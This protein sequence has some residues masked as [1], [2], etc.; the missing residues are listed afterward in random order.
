MTGPR[1]RDG[2]DA[3][4]GGLVDGDPRRLLRGEVAKAPPP[5]ERRRHVGF[6]HDRRSRAGDDVAGLDLGEV[7]REVD[8][9]VRRVAGGIRGNEVMGDLGG[10]VGRRTRGLQ[11]APAERFERVERDL[12][13]RWLTPWSG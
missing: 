2:G 1:Q 3:L 7:R 6:A 13:H 8:H 12:G 9:P 5:V 10:D 11:Q 4:G